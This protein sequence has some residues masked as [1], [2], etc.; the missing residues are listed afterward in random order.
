MKR[1][2]RD[3]TMKFRRAATLV[4]TFQGDRVAL[5][6]FLTHDN[7][8]C[9]AACLGFLSQLDD[10][11]SAEKLFEHFPDAD[12][13]DLAAQIPE[14]VKFNALIVAG[15]KQAE[16]DERYRR[17][18]QWGA[19][20]GFFHFSI[21]GTRFVTGKP[22]R[23]FIRK[24]KA[25]RPSPRLL[26]S[27]EEGRV[28]K[29]PGTDLQQQPFALMHKR[30]SRRRFD[31]EPVPLQVLADCLF[32]GNGIVDFREDDVYG[33]LPITMTPSGGARNPFEL[34][35]YAEKI[36]GLKPGFYHYGALKRDLGLVRA[37][38]VPV[39]AMLGTQKWPAKAAAIVFL[40]AHF[41]RSMWKYHM[42]IAYRVV[43]MEAGFIGQNIALAATHHGLSAVPSGALDEDLIEGYLGT[44]AV[45]SSLVL[46]LVLG[47]PYSQDG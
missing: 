11:Q 7:F 27:N 25:W 41:P 6:N 13:S 46:S 32:A 17:D 47:R 22:A 16:L 40:V 2:R 1:K 28:V 33:R 23:E 9:S 42:P 14:L 19:S 10:W 26:Q 39:A 35:V 38:K 45:E 36:G 44:P 31:G 20:A 43:M 30:R 5:H 34:Y 21:R 24:R 37:G 8:T 4:A 15:T 29:L 12:R 3:A 18:W